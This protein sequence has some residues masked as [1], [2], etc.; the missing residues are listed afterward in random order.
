MRDFGEDKSG[1][2]RYKRNLFYIQYCV[3]IKNTNLLQK[4]KI[5]LISAHCS[6]SVLTKFIFKHS[7]YKK[8]ISLYIL[9]QFVVF[10]FKYFYCQSRAKVVSL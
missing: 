9:F 2:Y 5:V 8:E 7:T 6:L 1:K 3:P 4:M 10:I